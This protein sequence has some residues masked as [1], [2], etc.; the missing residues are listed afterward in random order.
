MR[1]NIQQCAKYEKE[2]GREDKRPFARPV[3]ATPLTI[4]VFCFMRIM[5]GNDAMPLTS[6]QE[7]IAQREQLG[8][9]NF[10]LGI[11]ILMQSQKTEEVLFSWLTSASQSLIRVGDP[12]WMAFSRMRGLERCCW[13]KNGG[14]FLVVSLRKEEVD[15]GEEHQ[16]I[17]RGKLGCC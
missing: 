14:G 1:F 6:L 10:T 5:F 9:K 16:W 2:E 8:G 15:F 4:R 17:Q 3:W 7:I 13:D 12:Y 11:R